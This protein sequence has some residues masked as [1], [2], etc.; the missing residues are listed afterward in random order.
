MRSEAMGYLP[1]EALTPISIGN[2]IIVGQRS[3]ATAHLGRGC[4]LE[5][6]S[7]STLRVEQSPGGICVS[8]E[9]AS[10]DPRQRPRPNGYAAAALLVGGGVTWGLVRVRSHDERDSVSK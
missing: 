6:P 10:A 5:L 8:I 3:S 2:R 9:A 1:V 4:F 7:D